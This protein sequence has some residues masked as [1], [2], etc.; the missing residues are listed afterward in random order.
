MDVIKF[1]QKVLHGRLCFFLKL[2]YG[3]E[4]PDAAPF[5]K[6]AGLAED[7]TDEPDQIITIE[8]LDIDP[9]TRHGQ[10]PLKGEYVLPERAEAHLAA[11]AEQ[12]NA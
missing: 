8:E 12:E 7:S 1:N 5:F 11:V 6:A 9:L 3:F 2:S 4:D 10:G